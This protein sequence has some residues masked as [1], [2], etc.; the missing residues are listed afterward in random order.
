[1]ACLG[2][3][4]LQWHVTHT[5]SVVYRV[6]NYTA[7]GTQRYLHAYMYE[8]PRVHGTPWEMDSLM[9]L[10][11]LTNQ[12]PF[13]K[14]LMSLQHKSCVKSRVPGTCKIMV[15]RGQKLSHTSKCLR[16]WHMQ[17]DHPRLCKQNKIDIRIYAY[18]LDYDLWTFM[19]C[20]IWISSQTYSDQI[21]SSKIADEISRILATLQMLG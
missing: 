5:F 11:S 17:G 8:V 9:V 10:G 14:R 3:I 4:D 21:M 6:L 15:R 1:M 18:D 2:T 16:S 20:T 19:K 13:R 12:D 7:H